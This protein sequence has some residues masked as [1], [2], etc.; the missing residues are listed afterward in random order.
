VFAGIT[1]V[2]I[3]TWWIIAGLVGLID[4][5]F[6]VDT[7]DYP[8]KFNT[9]AWG[10]IH[11]ILGAIVLLAGLG[12]FS[13]AVWARILGVIM[14]FLAALVGFAWLPWYPLWAI[15]I[16]IASFGVIWALTAHGRDI[17]EV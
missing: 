1:M 5:D 8:F 13:G 14:A 17:S 6:Y 16:I 4:D 11:I 10:W 3:G 15:L 9:T 7:R 2:M 12:I